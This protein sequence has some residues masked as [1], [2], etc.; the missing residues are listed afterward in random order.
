[1]SAP[2]ILAGQLPGQRALKFSLLIGA[3]LAG[4]NPAVAQNETAEQKKVVEAIEKAQQE[5]RAIVDS[6]LGEIE[7]NGKVMPAGSLQRETVFLA[8]NN[9]IELKILEFIV[10]E[11]KARKPAVTSIPAR[12]MARSNVEARGARCPP[13]QSATT[14][15]R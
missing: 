5:R 11:W 10:A 14:L 6:L 15:L 8:G 1:M 7:V 3:L 2:R 13:S 4:G 9:L 12:V